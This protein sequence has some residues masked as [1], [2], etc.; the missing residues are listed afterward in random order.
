MRNPFL[1][2]L[3]A[4]NAAWLAA[5]LPVDTKAADREAV[6]T[7]LSWIA[8]LDPVIQSAQPGS[9]IVEKTKIAVKYRSAGADQWTTV[10]AEIGSAHEVSTDTSEV[11]MQLD[12]M[13]GHDEELFACHLHAHPASV[14]PESQ[15]PTPRDITYAYLMKQGSL[16]KN[17]QHHFAVV[18][19]LG[20]WFF[21][22]FDSYTEMQ[23]Y[24]PGLPLR[25]PSQIN[26]NAVLKWHEIVKETPA[27]KKPELFKHQFLREIEEM[28][29]SVGVFLKYVSH[30]EA[31]RDPCGKNIL[32]RAS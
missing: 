32:Q 3:A 29:A 31:R 2:S 28:Y 5:A 27:E 7:V 14:L 9:D 10:Y 4:F 17:M 19:S 16:R 18:D 12:A 6:P 1:R 13:F 25:K 21:R 15:P 11:R 26:V 22:N 30:G 8:L 24:Y 20:V 23:R